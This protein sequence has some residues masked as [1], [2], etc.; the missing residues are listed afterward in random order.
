MKPQHFILV[1][2]R[3]EWF[4]QCGVAS[5]PESSGI[6]ADE[7]W[8]L[9]EVHSICH[10]PGSIV[11]TNVCTEVPIRPSKKDH[12]L[13]LCTGPGHLWVSMHAL[14]KPYTAKI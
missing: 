3:V 14:L 1:Q 8:E 7:A 2:H 5:L 4:D 10:V 6:L 9:I 12:V 11:S 13:L